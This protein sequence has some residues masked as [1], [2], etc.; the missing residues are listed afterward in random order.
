M[1]QADKYLLG[2]VP[3]V[4][5]FT[6]ALF[7]A[8]FLFL[9]V[10]ASLLT[11]ALVLSALLGMCGLVWSFIGYSRKTAA[12]VLVLLLIGVLG[13]L[14]GAYIGPLGGTLLWDASN[15]QLEPLP[16]L[17]LKVLLLSWLFLG[18]AVVGLMQARRVAGVLW[19][20]GTR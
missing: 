20:R 16:W 5:L 17:L 12:L 18:P 8:P 7:G 4:I 11:V 9:L 15:G 19:E 10:G 1:S 14:A 13:A 6:L 2:V 3:A